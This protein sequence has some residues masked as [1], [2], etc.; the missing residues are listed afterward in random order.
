MRVKENSKSGTTI[1]HVQA[2][3]LDT[4]RFGKTFYSITGSNE[5]TGKL[6]F[7]INSTTGKVILSGSLD[8]E[9]IERCVKL[10]VS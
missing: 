3:D 1:A 5:E 10:Y 7:H 8:R 2:S 4:G 6:L 9:N